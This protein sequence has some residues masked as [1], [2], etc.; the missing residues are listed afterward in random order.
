MRI[1][2]ITAAVFCGFILPAQSQQQEKGA[3]L[4]VGVVVANRAPI[5]KT[6]EFVGRVEAIGR[7]E[8]RARVTGYL[9]AVEFKEGDELKQGAPLY[10]IEKDQFEAAV[11]QARGAWNAARPPKF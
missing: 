5:A 6:A 3:V 1:L 8:V 4:P 10:R 7:V 2:I 11:E 9:E